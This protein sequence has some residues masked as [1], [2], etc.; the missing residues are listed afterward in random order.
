MGD[1]ATNPQW[2]EARQEL[3]KECKF[4]DLVLFLGA[5]V[6]VASKLPN[7]GDLVYMLYA[8]AVNKHK[9][10]AKTRPFF[11]Y[12]QAIAEHLKT[13]E[14]ESLEI[15]A[16]KTRDMYGSEPEQQ[17]MF[18][19][20]LRKLLY[21]GYFES[22]DNE[23]HEGFDLDGLL[24]DNPTLAGV[25][26]LCADPQ[27][28]ARAVVTYNY[29]G[30]L[31]TALGRPGSQEFCSIF[32]DSV[33]A[34]NC[35]PI[36]H[37]HGYLPPAR[38]EGSLAED[39]IFTEEQYHKVSLDPYHWSNLIQ[40]TSMANSTGLMI[41]LSLEDRNIRRLLQALAMSPL[42]CN[43][44]ALLKKPGFAL[45][46][47]LEAADIHERAIATDNQKRKSSRLHVNPNNGEAMPSYVKQIRAIVSEMKDQA[48]EQ[49][50]TL[51]K[52][53]GITPI[54]FEDFSEIEPFC[55]KIYFGE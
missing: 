44:Y 25:T 45:P 33:P 38:G 10:F 19:E 29:D 16:R 4:R 41:G 20:D 7:W 26:Q 32:D 27:R 40:L 35:L 15:T 46:S 28:G 55:R 2:L 14:A 22:F 34:R 11:N 39:I 8:Y 31:E 17:E 36:Y 18:V 54:W 53:L 49:Q 52:Q 21:R 23:G 3:H 51:L 6:S 5:G 47:E 43:I 30:L 37:P 42:K 12:L 13:K 50:E 24:Y 1:I 9:P 48:Q